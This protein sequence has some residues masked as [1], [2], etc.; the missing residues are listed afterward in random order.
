M[1]SLGSKSAPGSP[2]E[3]DVVKESPSSDADVSPANSD[4]GELPSLPPPIAGL[5]K[6]ERSPRIHKRSSTIGIM[7]SSSSTNNNSSPTGKG[8]YKRSVSW[9]HMVFAKEEG[10]L[11][12]AIAMAQAEESSST[13]IS[14]ISF[15]NLSRAVPIR[16]DS[17]I[18]NASGIL[19]FPPSLRMGQPLRSDSMGSMASILSPVASLLRAHPVRSP[20]NSFTRMGSQPLLMRANSVHSVRSAAPS[21]RHGHAVRSESQMTLDTA[22][23]N[24]NDDDI[25]LNSEDYVESK[26][27]LPKGAAWESPFAS[28]NKPPLHDRSSSF[29]SLGT[30]GDNTGQKEH[31][32]FI[33]Q[34]SCSNYEG[35]G[36]EIEELEVKESLDDARKLTSMISLSDYSVHSSMA[37]G[38]SWRSVKSS[39]QLRNGPPIQSLD[40]SFII[41]N[42][43][44]ERHSSEILR[45]LS[46]EDLL[47]SHNLGTINGGSSKGS[48]SRHL[49]ARQGDHSSVARVNGNEFSDSWELDSSNSF[50]VNAANAWAVLEDEYAEG[51]GA[52]NSLPFQIFG[53]SATDT[54]CHPHVLSPPLM[55]SLQNF[56]PP[57]I[58]EN[59]FW[60]KYSLVRDGAS[61]P[62]LLRHIRG[63]RH[64][65]IAIETVEGEVFG[66]FTSSPWRKNWNYYGNGEAFLWRMRRTRSEKDAQYSVLDQAKLESELDVFYWTG[67]NDLVQYCTHDMIAVGGGAL[68][69]DVRD[70]EIDTAEEREL[71]PQN[72]AFTKADKGG[73][74]LAI[75]SELLRGTSSS[76]ATFQSPPLSKAHP[77]GSPFEILNMEIWTLSPC[78]NESDAETLE[79]K[80][81]FLEGYSRQS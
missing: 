17:I 12:E 18:S 51:Y 32:V 34:A 40:D 10:K 55:E 57:I 45:S 26:K 49:S 31:P 61:L 25:S 65:L 46:N 1:S 73:F 77:N 59:N 33:R 4:L 74:G 62:S 16:S 67:R 72:P 13:G 42:I 48:K 50:A 68:Q 15:P 7:K 11:E 14:V 75:D 23:L 3:K 64:T 41:K 22:A 39:T 30:S 8:K 60:L 6:S 80:T 54:G 38:K 37:L 71:P 76:C 28:K 21:L 43:D 5:L 47:T 79:M 56:L 52:D 29:A 69:D 63:T 35:I 20:R 58:S 27:T 9:G 53:T 24:I 36:V 19:S 2:A 70:D 81:L 78:A 44:F 66:S